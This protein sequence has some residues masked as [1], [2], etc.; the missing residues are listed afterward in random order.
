MTSRGIFFPPPQDTRM[1]YSTW[2]SLAESVVSMR[3]YG[4]APT[5][6]GFHRTEVFPLQFLHFPFFFFSFLFVGP[7]FFFASFRPKFLLVGSIPD[8][9]PEQGRLPPARW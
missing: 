1:L 2:G 5:A 7:F 8:V 3:C 6:P 9:S 4:A